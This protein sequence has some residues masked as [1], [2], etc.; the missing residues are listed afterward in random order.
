MIDYVGVDYAVAIDQGEVINQGEYEEM[1]DFA[2]G[3]VQQVG[4]LPEQTIKAELIKQAGLLSQVIMEKRPAED[5][6]QLTVQMQR[7]ITTA[8]KVVVVPRKQPN[9]LKAQRQY[10]QLCASCHGV[11]GGGDGPAAVGME[12]EPINFK[13]VERYQQRSL[14]GLYSTI[15]QGVADTAMP[16]YGHLSEEERWSLAFYLGG[17][18]S[19]SKAVDV[20]GSPLLE[21]KTMTTTTPA[22]AQ[23]LDTEKGADIMVY[24]RHHPELFYGKKSNLSFTK[25]KLLDALAAY[26]SSDIEMAYQAAVEA[27]LEG[28]ELEE[29]NIKA[30]DKALM[31]EIEAAM[32][33]LRNKIRLNESAELI[34]NEILLINQKLTLAEQ[35]LSDTSLSG[36]TAF[37]S[38]FFI[39]LR[40]GLE[41][42]LIVAA[43]IAFL[44]RTERRDGLRYIHIGWIS[45]LIM[46]VITWWVSLSLVTISGASREITEGLA[47]IVA[48][49]VLL[50]VG[51]WMHSKVSAAKWK[52][53]IDDNMQKALDSGTLWTLTG[54][55]FIAVYRE[56]F[57]TILF[58]QAL[59]VQTNEA[60]KAMG[61]GGFMAALAV[62]VVAAWLI[63][64]YSA[65]LP[66]RQFFA[67]TGALMFILAVI[68]AGKGVAALQEAGLII[69]TPVN[70]IRLDLFG[71]YPNLQGL[72][73]QL[74]MIILAVILWNKTSAKD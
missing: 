25:Q 6:R 51:F 63:M 48:A 3:I 74:S 4:A 23:Q 20:T 42:L 32:T 21:L 2:A 66:L 64:R 29:Q 69:S 16:A 67:V 36:M 70:F 33:G 46:G 61:L 62:L 7:Q 54:L 45:A 52:K 47:A 56:A 22:Q 39:L 1:Q 19:Q 53:F 55:S 59:W 72:L 40:E 50:Y 41:A 14:F 60:G 17:M 30:L 10:Q 37:S 58:Y 31:L 8:Y 49:V 68:F 28:F 71:I 43:L 12:P 11:G 34:E 18:A 35:L 24:L 57:E 9:L 65:R 26:K 27:Y 13:D 44:I 73:V 38:A 15:T 5:I